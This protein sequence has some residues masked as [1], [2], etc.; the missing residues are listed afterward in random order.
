MP[1]NRTRPLPSSKL[2]SLNYWEWRQ[3]NRK[4]VRSQ[5]VWPPRSWSWHLLLHYLLL[6]YL[7]FNVLFIAP[8]LY[9]LIRVS[10]CSNAPTLFLLHFCF[11]SFCISSPF[12]F[13]FFCSFSSVILFVL[14]LF[15]A[16]YFLLILN[17]LLWFPSPTPASSLR[18]PYF[19]PFS[20]FFTLFSGAM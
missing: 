6:V 18:F 12:S 15:L 8:F 11:I 7:N 16:F 4:K 3:I 20:S 19:P 2:Y 17:I 10:F 5:F 9:I 13:F 14:S 1:L